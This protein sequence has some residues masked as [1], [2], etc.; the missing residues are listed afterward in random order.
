MREVAGLVLLNKSDDF[1]ARRNKLCEGGG[2][3]W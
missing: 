2:I 1:T 3:I